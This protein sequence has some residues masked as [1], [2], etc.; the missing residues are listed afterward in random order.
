[1]VAHSGK[2]PFAEPGS[3]ISKIKIRIYLFVA[4]FFSFF[5]IDLYAVNSSRTMPNCQS[6]IYILCARLKDT[7]M[8]CV[9]GD[10]LPASLR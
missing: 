1:M 7:D 2:K 10:T 3:V 9:F 5:S 4:F 8:R 6:S